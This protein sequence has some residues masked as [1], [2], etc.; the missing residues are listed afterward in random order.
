M[1]RSRGVHI[2]DNFP[3]FLTT[4]HTD[5][6]IARIVDRV[7]GIGGRDAGGR[8]P[9]Q[10]Q[11]VTAHGDGRRAPAGAGRAPRARR[12]MAS[13]A[14]FVPNPEQ[15]GKYL[16]VGAMNAVQSSSAV[17][18]VDYD[19]FAEAHVG[20]RGADHRSRSARSGWPTS[21]GRMPRLAY[22]ESISLRSARRARCRGAARGLQDVA[23]PARRPALQLRARW[24][25]DVRARLG[26]RWRSTSATCARWTARNATQLVERRLRL[27][28]D[29]PF[30]A[31]ARTACFAPNCCAWRPTS[32][33]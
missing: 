6:D 28:V 22:N 21:L 3:C 23:G 27:A 24:R 15:P 1:M 4:A 10:A 8:L 7:Q 32:T 33:S 31:G 14:W 26:Q 30:V 16:K 13:P 12:R 2:L 11:R 19:P 20:A 9:A 29:T 18:P 17:D 25:N 5:A